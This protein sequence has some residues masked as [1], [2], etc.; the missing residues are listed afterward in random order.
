MMRRFGWMGMTAFGLVFL[1][2]SIASA[3]PSR[4]FPGSRPYLPGRPPVNFPPP[5]DRIKPAASQT[6][7]SSADFYAKNGYPKVLGDAVEQGS[8]QGG[9]AGGQA[10]GAAGGGGFQGNIGNQIGSNSGGTIFGGIFGG[11][12]GGGGAGFNVNPPGGGFTGG[13]FSGVVPKGFGFGGTPDITSSSTNPL[14]GG[15]NR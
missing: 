11:G 14:R 7:F 4:Q 10:G 8:T 15:V 13:G 3:Q 12:G 6:G 1:A 5:N 2:T 9:Q